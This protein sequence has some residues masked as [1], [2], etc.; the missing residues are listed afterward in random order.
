MHRALSWGW[1]VSCGHRLPH[2]SGRGE[3]RERL[4]PALPQPALPALF[5]HGTGDGTQSLQ[6]ARHPYQHLMPALSLPLVSDL[7]LWK[8]SEWW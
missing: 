2:Y 3:A 7:L 8:V 6:H 5:I 4:P 1:S